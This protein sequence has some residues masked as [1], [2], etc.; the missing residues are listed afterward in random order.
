MP[1]TKPTRT[2][3]YHDTRTTDYWKHSTGTGDAEGDIELVMRG[4]DIELAMR[5]ETSNSRCGGRHRTRDAEGDIELMV[6]RETA[7]SRCGGHIELEMRR[8]TSNS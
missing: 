2:A 8:E 6:R 7:N 3:H 5:W 1:W 4:G